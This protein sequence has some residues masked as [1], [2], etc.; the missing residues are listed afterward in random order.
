[1][2]KMS[3]WLRKWEDLSA[4]CGGDK[5]DLIL[6]SDRNGGPLRSGDNGIVEGYGNT[7]LV[8]GQFEIKQ[9]LYR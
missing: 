9:C 7:S 4:L 8:A 6:L 1:M 3:V 5:Q 2:L